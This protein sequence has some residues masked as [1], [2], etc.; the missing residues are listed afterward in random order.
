MNTELQEKIGMVLENFSFKIE[1]GKVRELALALGDSK[2]EYLNGEK[3][4][5]TFP[6]V[7]EYCGG[8]YDS[9]LEL[10]LDGRKSVHGEQEYE[11]IGKIKVGSMISV[12]TVVVDA[13]MKAGMKFVVLKKEFIN[14]SGEL[15]V[16]GRS[17]I[18]ETK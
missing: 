10:G 9:A 4:P 11:Y 12:K 7:I 13:F 8:G 15:V 3:L 1:A 17:T 18:I 16:I 2:V 14:E 6:T 5:P